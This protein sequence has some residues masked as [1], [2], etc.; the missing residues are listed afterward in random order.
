VGAVAVAT[1]VLTF[2]LVPTVSAGNT[3]SVFIGSTTDGALTSTTVSAGEGTSFVVTVANTGRQTLNHVSLSIGRDDNPAVEANPQTSI[4]PTVPVA[5][6]NGTSATA[7]GCTGGTGAPLSCA[8]GTLKK[9]ASWTTTVALGSTTGV[10]AEAFPIKAVAFAKEGGNDNG[11]N[12][13]TFAAEGTI[14]YLPFSCASVTAYRAIGSRIVTTPCAVIGNEKQ[15][16]SVVLPDGLTT[17]TLSEGP[18]GTPCPG[19]YYATCIGDPVNAQIV[20]DETSDVV[21]WTVTYNVKGIKVRLDKLRV[22]HYTDAGVI[23]PPGGF[24]LKH[25]ACASG[26]SINCGTAVLS[27]DCRTL[28]ITFQTAGNGKTRLLG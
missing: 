15:Q 7:S 3:R 18:D 28:T 12:M 21:T 26:S 5:F 6:P 4:T 24:S 10:N 8:V 19:G 23:D 27:A 1:S 16:S 17:I 14:T 25:N 11:A 22:I 20:G 9:G 13:D 2:V